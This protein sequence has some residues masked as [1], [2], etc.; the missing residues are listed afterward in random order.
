M[1]TGASSWARIQS[2]RIRREWVGPG[3]ASL[4]LSAYAG[5]TRLRLTVSFDRLMPDGEQQRFTMIAPLEIT[6]N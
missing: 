6:L 5:E 1:M 4:D 2:H 3:I